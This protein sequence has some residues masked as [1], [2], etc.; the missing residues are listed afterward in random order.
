ML[1][2]TALGPL[3]SVR[4]AAAAFDGLDP[5]PADAVSWFEEGAGKFRLEVYVG[6]EQ[7]ADAAT[8][9]V[10]QVSPDLHVHA[11]AL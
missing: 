4:A 1:I 5:S 7:D 6:T 11:A 3:P 9:V 2:L 10:A 8:A